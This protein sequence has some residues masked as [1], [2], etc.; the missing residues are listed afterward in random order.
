MTNKVLDFF[1][2]SAKSG[3]WNSLYHSDNPANYPF[4]IRIK[5]TLELL[6]NIQNK[7]VCDLGCGTGALISPI[8]EK[9]A[10]YTGIDFSNEMLETIKSKYPNEVLN[11]KINLILINFGKD[12]F[13]KKFDLLIG[14][15]FIEYFNEPQKIINQLYNLLPKDGELIL[16]FPNKNSLD[17]TMI[18]ALSIIR[19]LVK[20]IFNIGKVN[21]PRKMW[22]RFEAKKILE[23]EGFK[24]MKIKNYYFNILAYPFTKLLPRISFFL[25]KKLEYSPLCK[26]NFFTNGFII[27][28]KK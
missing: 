1:E 25:S 19:Y 17:F 6:E 7:N 18:R 27:S 14:L 26:I 9:Q 4:I 16:S 20:K 2:D 11:K 10:I 28:A 21:P 8:L 3:E 13:E 5:K 22:S 23:S 24:I 12:K 15:G